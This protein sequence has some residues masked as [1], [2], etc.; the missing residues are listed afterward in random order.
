MRLIDADKLTP[1]NTHII[2]RI[3]TVDGYKIKT[4][5]I[6]CDAPTVEPCEDAVSRADML[7][8][9]SELF[10]IWDDYP[11]MIKEFGKTY[12]KLR[13][14]PPVTPQKKGKWTIHYDTW[15]DA[16]T[17]ISRYKCSECGK[18]DYDIDDFCPNCGADMRG[19][20]DGN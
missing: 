17:T 7:E 12:D 11:N 14:L 13:Q 2:E 10:D 15:G 3:E 18:F 8:T 6:I 16:I 4:Y 5:E 19:D 1:E 9:F 20:E